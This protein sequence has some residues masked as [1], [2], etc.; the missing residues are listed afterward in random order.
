MGPTDL[1][2]VADTG[3]PFHA[4]VT[5]DGTVELGGE[6]DISRL[7]AIRAVLDQ[8]LAGEARIMVDASAVTFIDS[9]AIGELLR[10]QVAATAQGRVLLLSPVSDRVA[11]V[12][13]MMDLEHL[14]LPPGP[15]SDG[16]A[17][18]PADA[19]G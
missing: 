4:A 7:E 8:A 17:A 6:L 11:E 10:Y 19:D 5:P 9:V 12:L 16:P 13:T 18:V 15:G 1:T 3:S 2:D 14:L